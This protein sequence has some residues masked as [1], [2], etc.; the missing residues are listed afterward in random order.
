MDL[1]GKPLR[2]FQSTSRWL[3]LALFMIAPNA[4]AG[5]AD[6]PIVA[7]DPPSGS[8][9]LAP[10]LAVLP[11]GQAVLT[12]LET[13]RAGGH[14]LHLS[15]FDGTRFGPEQ[16]IAR[17]SDWFANWADTPRVFALDD[18]RWLA[19]WLVKTA[20]APYAYHVHLASTVDGGSNWIAQGRLHS[21]RSPTEHGFVSYFAEPGGP[22]SAVWLDGRQTTTPDG[23]MT[24]RTASLIEGR[25]SGELLLD[26]RVCDCCQTAG[27]V[28][29]RG[30]V[31]VY[32]DR[33]EGEIRDIAIVRR[34]E[35]GW[36]RPEPVHADGWKIGGCPVNGP[37]VA[38]DGDT[39]VVVWFTMAEAT[40]RVRMAVSRDAGAHFDEPVALSTGSALGRVQ[41]VSHPGGF[42]T[43]W[44]DESDDGAVL[45][46]ARLDTGGALLDQRAMLSLPAGRVGGFPRIGVVG[47]QLLVTWT[48]TGNSGGPRPTTRVRAGLVDLSSN[49]PPG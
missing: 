1:T 35:R 6:V 49:P 18:E 7:L 14:A 10:D 47:E 22:A 15:R 5:G 19:H 24:L 33:T 13:D 48:A 34:T 30:P 4:H 45:R 16:T 29:D 31:V 11:S 20:E 39:V 8:G 46:M 28:T 9:S 43:T 12:W 42:I 44:M 23:P 25:R 21:D 26:E 36:S 38:A 27:A 41:V 17:G 40:P 37:D 3:L 2:L 32:R